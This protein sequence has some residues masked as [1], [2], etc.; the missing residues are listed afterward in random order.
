MQRKGISIYPNKS[1]VWSGGQQDTLSGLRAWRELLHH[2]IS[3]LPPLIF[4]SPR[5]LLFTAVIS[6][7]AKSC[8]DTKSGKYTYLLGED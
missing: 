6:I 5:S 2:V 8:T 1:V 4:F 7:L 3:R